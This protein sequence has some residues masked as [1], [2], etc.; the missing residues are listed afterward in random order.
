MIMLYRG[1]KNFCREKFPWEIFC[2]KF[3]DTIFPAFLRVGTEF[4]LNFTYTKTPIIGKNPF[5]NFRRFTPVYIFSPSQLDG[6]E[7]F[8]GKIRIGKEFF[9][10]E[11]LPDR[12]FPS[13]VT[14][15]CL[16]CLTTPPPL[17]PHISVRSP[18]RTTI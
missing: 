7:F 6:T 4:L 10:S 11:F 13:P 1:G 8:P 5:K 2:P 14:F 15:P 18:G 17:R 16:T 9:R 12:V 3:R